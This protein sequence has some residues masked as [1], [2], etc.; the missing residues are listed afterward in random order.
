MTR[1]AGLLLVF[2]AAAALLGHE[3]ARS[4]PSTATSRVD[5]L[6][7]EHRG[8][9]AV[10][11][12]RTVWPPYGQAAVR[13]GQSRIQAGPNQHEA[14][15]ASLAKVMTAYLMLRDRPLHPG[16]GGPTITLT[17]A[18]VADTDRR[19]EE[20]ESVASIAAGERLT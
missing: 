2:A 14:P 16:E 10:A 7:T 4:S 6:R 1:V 17:D 13:L 19:R 8:A 12:P 18:D 20:R 5:V 9:R 3:L 11:L 15:I